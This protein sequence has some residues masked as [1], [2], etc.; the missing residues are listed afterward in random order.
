MKRAPS[1]RS[2][3]CKAPGRSELDR[4]KMRGKLVSDKDK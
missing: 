1:N 4:F 3:G 2:M